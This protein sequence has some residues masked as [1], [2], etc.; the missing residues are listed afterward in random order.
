MKLI[1]WE[2]CTEQQ[3]YQILQ[4]PLQDQ[5]ERINSDVKKII[6]VVKQR[7]DQACIELTE[8][9]D[10]VRLK[11]IDLNLCDSDSPAIDEALAKSLEIAKENI[12]KVQS[13]LIP[14]NKRIEVIPGM[15]CER[16]FR[17]LESVGLYVP[18]GTAPLISTLLMLA[19]PA[20]VAGC[21]K[22]VVCTPPN[23]NGGIDPAMLYVAKLCGIEKIFLVGG[24]QAIAAMAYGTVTIPKVAKI[25]GPGNAWVTVAKQL[26][27]Q[28]PLGAAI[29]MP[30]G[31]SELMVIADQNANAQLIA[32]DLLSQ[33]EHSVDAQVM[34]CTTSSV[35]AE[36]VYEG[37]N[38]QLKSLSRKS[39]ASVALE[40][41][42]IILVDKIDAAINIANLYCPEHL[43]LQCDNAQDW[44]VKIRNVGTVFLGTNAAETFGDYI[45]GSNHVLPT[46]GAAKSYSGLSVIDYLRSF[47]VQSLDDDAVQQM[48][49]AT[50]SIASAEGL[51]A[52]E[53]AVKL[54][55][56]LKEE[57]V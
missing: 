45:S 18:G 2:R 5:S 14:Q 9:Y 38:L 30:A 11:R 43:S 50:M 56:R 40:N 28:D 29:D 51:D 27:A 34:L 31:P 46:N 17:P 33:A 21:E 52:H 42:K 32:A 55:L 13:G 23:K 15:V 20:Q 35:M 8:K 16:L 57:M 10:G 48:G 26:V 49:N 54:R 6:D 19:L 47:S 12:I 24:A 22:I 39:I 41:S 3:Q 37:I 1:D 25:F 44:I 4:R 53:N 36:A 7:G